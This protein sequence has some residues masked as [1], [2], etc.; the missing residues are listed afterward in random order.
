MG[1]NLSL[2]VATV[3][4]LLVEA[5]VPDEIGR[6]FTANF[7]AGCGDQVCGGVFSRVFPQNEKGK[8]ASEGRRRLFFCVSDSIL[9]LLMI[10]SSSQQ[11]W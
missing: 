11:A 8:A 3:H 1:V 9:I 10:C 4:V 2:T 5:A 6:D 7:F